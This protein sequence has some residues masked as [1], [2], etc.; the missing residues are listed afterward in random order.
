LLNQRSCRHALLAR[1]HSAA[2][3][4]FCRSRVRGSGTYIF[5]QHRHLRFLLRRFRVIDSPSCKP[6]ILE[7]NAS[8]EKKTHPPKKMGQE[9]EEDVSYESS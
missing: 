7:E 5:P 6:P 4:C 2:E 9:D 3:Q 8:E 1:L